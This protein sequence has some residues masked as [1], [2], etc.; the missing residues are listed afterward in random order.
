SFSIFL[1][2]ADPL[3]AQNRLSINTSL[4][5]APG[6]MA[7]TGASFRYRVSY[8]CDLV[9]IPSCNGATVTVDLPPE[10]EFVSAFFPPLDVAS[11]IHDGSPMGGTVIFTFQPSIPAGNTGDLDITVRFPNGSTPDGTTTTNLVDAASSSG[12]GLVTQM[13][14]L[15]PVTAVASPQVDLSVAL[16][17]FIDD[18]P[19]PGLYQVTIGPS[20][21]NGSLNFIDVTQ[22][23]LTLPTGVT[24]VSPNDGGVYD[25]LGNTVTWTNLGIITVPNTVTV[26]VGVTFAD[27][28]FTAGQTVSSFAEATV[29]ALG[30]PPGTVVG[31]LPFD[32]TLSAFSENPSARVRKRFADGRPNNLPP[33]EGQSF[34]YRIDIRN[35]GNI[36]LDSL[37]VV[38]D[39]DGAGG[40]I[41]PGIDVTA[42]STGAYNSGYTNTVTIRFTT[43]LSPAAVLGSSPG[44]I[45]ANFAVPAL[46]PGE[47]VTSVEWDFAGPIPAGMG[48]NTRAKITATA[49]PGFPAGTTVDNHVTANWTATIVGTC[50]D[51]PGPTS[52]SDGHSFDYD[53]NDPYTYLAPRKDE[54]TSGPYFPNDTVS[55]SFRIANNVLANDPATDPVVTD[56]LPEFL[57]FLGGTETYADN[58]TGVVLAAPGDFE[59]L[60]NY[61]STGRTLLRWN[62]T[63]D[64]DPGET[65][66]ISFDT[67]VETGVIFG[68]LTNQVGLSFP[69]GPVQQLC[70]GGSI[71][72]AADLDGDGNTADRLCTENENITIAAVAQLASRK[73][74]RGQCDGSFLPG[75]GTGTSLPGG[76]VDWRVTVQN[77][78]T[79]PMESFVIV[80]ILPF[81]GDTG[82]RDLTP[83]LS[84]FRPLLVQ[85]ISPPPGGAV[86]YSLSGNPCRPEV[87]GPTSGCDAP[88]WTPIPPDPITDVQSIMIDFGDRVVNPLDTLE[89]QWPMV[90]PADAPIDGSEGFNS[91]A[92]GSRRQD[93]GGFLGAEPNKVGIDA[94]CVPIPPDDARLGDFVWIDSNGDGDQDGGEVGL[95]DV[96]AELYDPGPDGL[97][98]TADDVLLLTTITAD[99]LGGNPGFYQFDALPAGDYY[100]LFYPPLG[101][102]VTAKGQ[103]GNGALDSDADPASACTDV[104]ILGPSE[105]NPD[106]DLGLVPETTASLG[107]Y[108]W[109]D[110]SGDGVQNEALVRGLNGVTVR[111]FTDDGDGS[112][113]PFADDGAPLMVTVTADDVFGNPGFY[114][115]EDLIAGVPYFVQF[116]EP[117]PATGFT[118][119]N[120]GGDD[121]VDS[122][123]RLSD[124]ASQVVTLSAGEHDP[125]IDAGIVLLT[126]NLGLGNLVWIDEDGNGVIDAAGDD[127]GS[128]DPLV[129]EAGVNGVRVNLYLDV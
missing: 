32:H 99:D 53:V 79:V 24:G 31:P 63:G 27:P 78:Q 81:V 22:L 83:R 58:G 127:D 77:V 87:G 119:R 85:P 44:N 9:S 60:P 16:D 21:N 91:F 107:N 59:V 114:L 1:V 25:A 92:F 26:S 96:R 116:V 84:L 17:G 43:N 68:T 111:L 55:F 11:G 93:D 49:N 98:R 102:A 30:E 67:R 51:P 122:D 5:D 70:A 64:L 76:L 75:V 28:P 19:D 12:T 3:E 4:L 94:T 40:D 109:F 62:L 38:D 10:L 29:D 124:G 126:G 7:D 14:D 115:F 46:A 101:F 129:P 6:N 73:F 97:A 39:G 48:P 35:N 108:V 37:T 103:G 47:R 80:D 34:T 128:Y 69:A 41:D 125:S 121:S 74:V 90:L 88:N 110:L 117:S 106:I 20:T 100:V 2:S 15:P 8:S 33:A 72:D 95:N 82:V 42:V 52:G 54:D 36:A 86:F 65:V 23:V 112:P 105:D 120:A 57:T 66:D 61:N 118:T 45:D 18:C 71:V 13:A 50:G 89:F 56:L 123:A 104:V 113:E